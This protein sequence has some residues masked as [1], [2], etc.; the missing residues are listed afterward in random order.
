[1]NTKFL[2]STSFRVN[3]CLYK[4][5]KKLQTTEQKL[6]YVLLSVSFM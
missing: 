3:Y 1:M 6:Y 5:V 2:N 4:L